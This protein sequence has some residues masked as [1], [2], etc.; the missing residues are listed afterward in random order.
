MIES[1]DHVPIAGDE[2]R[3]R[4]ACMYIANALFSITGDEGRPRDACTHNRKHVID[5]IYLPERGRGRTPCGDGIG[6]YN[7]KNKCR[8]AMSAQWCRSDCTLSE[9][10]GHNN[11]SNTINN[12][13]PL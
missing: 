8:K 7:N 4:D 10:K 2:G 9:G 1:G 6:S 5:R 11:N 3:P 13:W 12:N